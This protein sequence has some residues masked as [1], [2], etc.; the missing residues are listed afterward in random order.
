MTTLT[1]PS[2][3]FWL[4]IRSFSSVYLLAGHFKFLT[5]FLFI[6]LRDRNQ[7]KLIYCFVTDLLL[8]CYCYATFL[9]LPFFLIDLFY[10]KFDRFEFN[11]YQEQQYTFW[12]EN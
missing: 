9:L 7:Q 11:Y 8:L 5:S 4:V 12:I 1:T 10:L 2:Y 6:E 3:I